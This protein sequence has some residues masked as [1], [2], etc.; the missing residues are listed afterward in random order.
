MKENKTKHTP[1]LWD[2]RYE[3][4]SGSAY[5]CTAGGSVIAEVEKECGPDIPPIVSRKMPVEANARLIAAAPDM[6][7]ACIFAR[8]CAQ[9]PIPGMS[10]TEAHKKA[11]SM[12]DGAIAKAKG[13]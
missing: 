8:E 1:G 11:C 3:T 12:L 5:I 13:N 6:L 7:E 2:I 9:G 4:A 10:L